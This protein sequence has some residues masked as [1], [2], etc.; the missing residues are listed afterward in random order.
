M[1][2]DISYRAIEILRGVVNDARR[3][4]ELEEETGIPGTSWKN[5]WNKKQRPTIHMIEALARRWPQFAFWLATGI[6]D[7]ENG[8]TAPDDAW[9]CNQLKSDKEVENAAKDYF[10][11]KIFFQNSIYG[12]DEASANAADPA[13]DDVIQEK[14][15]A[16]QKML[17]TFFDDKKFESKKKLKELDYAIAKIAFN[18]RQSQLREYYFGVDSKSDLFDFSENLQQEM[19]KSRVEARKKCRKNV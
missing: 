16:I 5:V 11:L 12:L 14:N 6:T 13:S 10:D 9:T 1:R 3:T 19:L 4:K 2:S 18:R 7:E 17:D 8:H 15:P